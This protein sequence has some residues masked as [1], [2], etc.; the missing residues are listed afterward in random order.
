MGNAINRLCCGPSEKHRKGRKHSRWRRILRICSCGSCKDN[1]HVP[2][3]KK[4]KQ[5]DQID[6]IECHT[7]DKCH[8]F[9][10]RPICYCPKEKD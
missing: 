2:S 7:S 8:D 1:G 3:G 6:D 9:K 10:G 5:S 4:Y